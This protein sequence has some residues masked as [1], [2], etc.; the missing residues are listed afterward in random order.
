MKSADSSTAVTIDS[1]TGTLVDI[2]SGGQAFHVQGKH[3]FPA[4]ANASGWQVKVVAAAPSSGGAVTVT[5][6]LPGKVAIII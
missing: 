2:V 1:V 6:T 4:F 3:T 5:Q